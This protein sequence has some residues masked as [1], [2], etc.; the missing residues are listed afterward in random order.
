MADQLSSSVH[1][2]IRS[3]KIVRVLFRPCAFLTPSRLSSTWTEI[4]LGSRGKCMML[5]DP[6]VR[7]EPPSSL[8][9]LWQ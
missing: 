8:T 4:S 3:Q 1:A 6:P 2:L 5:V 7:S 9:N